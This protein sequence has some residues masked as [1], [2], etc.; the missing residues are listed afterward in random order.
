MRLEDIAIR[1][2]RRTPWE[3]MDLGHAMLRAWARP[4]YGA[5]FATYWPAG[6]L[7][8]LLLWPWQEYAIL[9]IWW[10]KPFFDRILLQVFSR[11]VFGA[12]TGLRETLRGLPALLRGPGMLSGL[13]LRRISMARSF[14]LP[15]WQLEEQRGAAAR[16]RFRVLALRYRGYAVWLTFVC[17]NLSAILLFGMYMLLAAMAPGDSNVFSP[18]QWFSEDIPDAQRFAGNLLFMLAETL[19][20]PLYVASG[21]SLYLNRR[22]ELEAWDIELGFRRLAERRTSPPAPPGAR[23]L[24]LLVAATAAFLLVLP[25]AGPAAAE[26]AA[27]AEVAKVA[28]VAE[29]AEAAEAADGPESPP[30]DPATGPAADA[31]TV[32]R[33]PPTPARRAMDAVLADP[34]FGQPKQD[35]RWQRRT[36]PPA[37]EG[38]GAWARALRQ[39]LEFLAEAMKGFV[40][41]VAGLALAAALYLA[42]RLWGGRSRAVRREA[43]EFLFG[44]DL[45]PASLPA[46]VAAAARAAWAAGRG[47][48]AL[49]LLYRGALVALI[50]R[51]QVEFAAG[52]TEEDCLRR[53]AGHLPGDA[54]GC[55]SELVG[56]WGRAAYGHQLPTPSAMGALLDQWP[57]HFAPAGAA[58]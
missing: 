11:R 48:E 25:A 56:C 10:W 34:V 18:G 3:A 41:I 37:E 40:W 38:W 17:A 43:P 20:E 53:A 47:V 49:S 9:V 54:G 19:V 6:I 58:P 12:G 5:W 42:V 24:A 31:A 51:H 2:R 8:L 30:G 32:R 46:D 57:R 26:T 7:L 55:F 39:V 45:R 14:L 44:L 23:P 50:H 27:A 35:W 1:L 13:T 21:F 33:G 29:V 4:A 15:V 16:G 28:K 36:R 22:S 52:D